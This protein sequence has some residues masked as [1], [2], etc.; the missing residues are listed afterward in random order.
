MRDGS[1]KNRYTTHMKLF[2]T[3]TV[4]FCGLV[5][6]LNPVCAAMTSTNYMISWDSLNSGGDESSVSSNYTMYDTVGQLVSGGSASSNYTLQAGYR[7]NDDFSLAM[8]V[9]GQAATEIAYSDLS[10]PSTSVTVSS[11]ASFSVGELIAVVENKGFNEMITVGRITS[12][13]GNLITVDSWQGDQA[14][15]S[16]A[17]VGGND[18]VYRLTAATIPMG[19]I[20]AGDEGVARAGISVF[21]SATSGHTVYVQGDSLMS[22]ALSSV[23]IDAV[24]DG[25]VSSNAEEYGAEAVGPHAVSPSVDLGVTTTQRAVMSSTVPAATIPDRLA[26]LF[27]MGVTSATDDEEY[28]QTVYFTLTAN[29]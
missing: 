7:A 26:L 20:G 19:T 4:A 27:K 18:F 16:P 23:F 14:L 13:V 1:I 17:V 12:I 10:V 15:M 6:A 24:T 8:T 21:S 22:D 25:A 2:F 29:F 3:L 5:L 11:A 28:S 9:G